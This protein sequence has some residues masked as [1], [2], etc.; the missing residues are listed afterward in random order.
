MKKYL[1]LDDGDCFQIDP[2]KQ[3]VRLACCDCGL[4]HAFIMKIVSGKILICV[5]RNERATAQ[6][7]RHNQFECVPRKDGGN[8]V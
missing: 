4:T 1:W 7:R 5:H 6:L 3:Y 8:G 2:K